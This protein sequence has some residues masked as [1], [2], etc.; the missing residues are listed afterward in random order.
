MPKYIGPYKIIKDFGNQSFRVDLPASLKQRGVHDSFHA[1]LLRI[2]LPND[3][4]LFPGRLDSQIGADENT[5]GEWA[6]DKILS[7]AGS[8]EKAVFEVKWKAGDITW[9]PYSH[10]EHL[11]VLM[12]YLELLGVS[13]ITQLPNG[14]GNP[15][16]DPQIFVGSIEL[17]P[18][19][20]LSRHFYINHTYFNALS[21]HPSPTSPSSY[22]TSPLMP[23][24]HHNC[25]SHKSF[26]NAGFDSHPTTACRHPNFQ[27]IANCFIVKNSMVD[28]PVVLSISSVDIEH[29]IRINNLARTNAQQALDHAALSPQYDIVA[30]A[31]NAIPGPRRF[32]MININTGEIEIEGQA[33]TV[34]EFG[35]N[36]QTSLVTS[37]TVFT[38]AETDAAHKMFH[39][40]IA[41]QM[42][43]RAESMKERQ[44]RQEQARFDKAIATFKQ[45]DVKSA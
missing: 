12:T 32:A 23:R 43:K 36:S 14:K 35:L 2:H 16:D 11:Y 39:Q 18:D 25:K 34:T 27:K 28:P 41:F 21:P 24:D 40:Q 20:V 10:I 19:R 5:D 13:H 33:V 42:K 44:Q 31:Y 1:A 4:R 45:G 8:G 7:H 6:V 17:D 30:K 3:D 15:P 22:L 26:M 9:L 37:P 38:E 29:F